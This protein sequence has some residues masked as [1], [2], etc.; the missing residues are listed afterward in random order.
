MWRLEAFREDAQ[1]LNNDKVMKGHAEHWVA[2]TLHFQNDRELPR[3][4][5]ARQL[6]D[7]RF[8][9]LTLAA[10]KI[11]GRKGRE[12][13]LGNQRGSWVRPGKVPRSGA[14][15]P[16]ELGHDTL[17]IQMFVPHP[18][19]LSEPSATGILRTLRH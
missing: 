5:P 12:R 2:S 3:V 16:V 19:K 15:V 17:S 6:S 11:M 9:K 13:R 14:S 4:L 7:L 18:G 1:G 8:R 10:V